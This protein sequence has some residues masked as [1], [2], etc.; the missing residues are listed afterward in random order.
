MQTQGTVT[1]LPLRRSAR[2]RKLKQYEDFVEYSKADLHSSRTEMVV[3]TESEIRKAK[4]LGDQLTKQNT[5][6][7]G[8]A[9]NSIGDSDL[10]INEKRQ[11]LCEVNDKLNTEDTINKQDKHVIKDERTHV[12]GRKINT[13]EIEEFSS[14]DTCS[15]MDEEDIDDKDEMKELE[16]IM[17]TGYRM[18]ISVGIICSPIQSKEGNKK[19]H[20]ETFPCGQCPN[21]SRSPGAI[22]QIETKVRCLNRIN[23]QVDLQSSPKSRI[24]QKD[25]GR[26]FM[27]EECGA[28]L[29]SQ[30]NL[31]LHRQNIHNSDLVKCGNCLQNIRLSNMPTHKCQGMTKYSIN[32]IPAPTEL[33][34]RKK[35]L[36]DHTEKEFHHSSGKPFK[37]KLCCSRYRTKKLLNTHINRMHLIRNE[38]PLHCNVCN[39]GFIHKKAFEIHKRSHSDFRPYRCRL[40]SKTFRQVGHVKDHLRTHG[41]S[42]FFCHICDKSFKQR[43][44][45][46][47]HANVH[48]SCT[49]P[50]PSKPC[51]MKFD[52]VVNLVSHFMDCMKEQNDT[53]NVGFTCKFCGQT[54]CDADLA[55]KHIQIHVNDTYKCSQCELNFEDFKALY[56]HM[57]YQHG[58]QGKSTDGS[59]VQS[60]EDLLAMY[61]IISADQV[62]E[63]DFVTRQED[64]KIDEHDVQTD[65]MPKQ[66]HVNSNSFIDK[67][68]AHENIVKESSYKDLCLMEEESTNIVLQDMK[69]DFEENVTD[70]EERDTVPLRLQTKNRLE[71][72]VIM[73]GSVYP[74]ELTEEHWENNT[75]IQRVQE[76]RG[77]TVTV[78]DGSIME[79]SQNTAEIP[80]ELS[81]RSA[82]HSNKSLP[83]NVK[84]CNDQQDLVEINGDLDGEYV[85]EIPFA[86]QTQEK[87]TVVAVNEDNQDDLETDL[88]AVTNE[89]YILSQQDRNQNNGKTTECIV[90]GRRPNRQ[91]PK[92]QMK[93]ARCDVCGK[94]F[95]K[96]CELQYHMNVHLPNAERTFHCQVCGRGFANLRVLKIHSRTHTGEKPFTCS[97]CGKSFRQHGHLKTHKQLHD[98]D[99]PFKCSFCPNSYINNSKLRLHMKQKHSHEFNSEGSFMCS[100]C[101][102]KFMLENDL[103]VHRL[104]H[105]SIEQQLNILNRFTVSPLDT[106]SLS[107]TSETATDTERLSQEA[108]SR[109]MCHSCGIV[110]KNKQCLDQHVL[111]F[112]TIHQHKC[113]NC[114][115]KFKNSDRLSDHMKHCHSN[116]YQCD[117]CGEVLSSHKRFQRHKQRLHAGRLLTCSKCVRWFNTQK[118]FVNHLQS[119][120]GTEFA[121]ILQQNETSELL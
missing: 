117:Q 110:L 49:F 84:Y 120:R 107:K 100:I 13:G 47:K 3:K 43:S 79:D 23:R 94:T 27:C 31:K 98:K 96:Y 16:D 24:S 58:K 26:S 97:V 88:N 42:G 92:S 102:D 82:S 48:A 78:V 54:Q 106:V 4:V 11:L 14:N 35:V 41:M 74:V 66:Y 121:E 86:L 53:T 2:E 46:I 85:E 52:G 7:N 93:T 40:C 50:C 112:H 81:C 57:N 18:D 91:T 37:C 118:A 83:E 9:Q 65:D 17:A 109:L 87:T 29:K 99:F 62:Y 95:R 33:A 21:M 44:P 30:A 90:N 32:K 72:I 64:N 116:S 104:T 101:D 56:V 67:G 71:E 55:V 115:K 38:N 34:E 89:I 108:K 28:C 6:V 60:K 103:N 12:G 70:R 77:E 19:A 1:V 5:D 114:K 39:K 111:N 51:S 15:V 8:S 10:G 36:N 68:F 113:E 105:F 25:S 63:A 73:D 119:C 61:D 22:S 20:S 80:S 76:I 59:H 69:K 75:G 45:W